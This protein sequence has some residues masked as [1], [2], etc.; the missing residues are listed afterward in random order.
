M[1]SP[2]TPASAASAGSR[3]RTATCEP[4]EAAPAPR[5][6]STKRPRR[7]ERRQR[8]KGPSGVAPAWRRANQEVHRE[9]NFLLGEAWCNQFA[10]LLRH[11]QTHGTFAVD[12]SRDPRLAGWCAKQRSRRAQ[13]TL[14]VPARA[15]LEG[16]GFLA[17]GGGSGGER[18]PAPAAPAA[19]PRTG[20]AVLRAA[21]AVSARGEDRPP[22]CGSAL[23]AERDARAEYAAHRSA[24][25]GRGVSFPPRFL[26][27][28]VAPRAP[29]AASSPPS[30]PPTPGSTYAEYAA[31]S[32]AASAASSTAASLASSDDGSGFSLSAS[33][34]AL[35]PSRDAP[36]DAPSD[37][38]SRPSTRAVASRP[39]T[40]A[41]T[42]PRPKSVRFDLR[43][44][45]TAAVEANLRARVA[46]CDWCGSADRVRTVAAGARLCAACGRAAT[47]AVRRAEATST[48][49]EAA[50][51]AM[52]VPSDS[53]AG[54]APTCAFAQRPLRSASLPVLRAAAGPPRRPD[55][56]R[57]QTPVKIRR[58]RSRRRRRRAEAEEKREEERAEA[59]Q[60]AEES[61]RR[62]RSRARTPPPVAS[63][64]ARWARD[65][66]WLTLL[67]I[68]THLSGPRADL[69]RWLT[70][71]RGKN[72]KKHADYGGGLVH[73]DGLS[74]ATE[75][76]DNEEKRKRL[77][78]VA[79]RA[80]DAVWG[81]SDDAA[82]PTTAD[83]DDKARWV[84]TDRHGWGRVERDAKHRS[85]TPPNLF[86]RQD[87]GLGAVAPSG[88]AP[89]PVYE[90]G[91]DRR[92]GRPAAEARRLF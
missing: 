16:C 6:K 48:A 13:G 8:A 31:S 81:L 53:I 21:A 10:E 14:S 56:I 90:L 72:L 69:T 85:W 2:T 91:L 37:A 86:E 54:H 64:M 63:V 41:T 12:A 75:F 3:V 67:A 76:F 32:N 52:A 46:A 43:T 77:N 1:S 30:L 71:D 58:V 38:D 34:A 29:P 28:A 20:A 18:A 61:A 15:R 17:V 62:P 51:A 57:L 47:P 44:N 40:N 82:K 49:A 84:R 39:S 23:R 50:A 73:L 36:S 59:A 89:M 87:G 7:R 88:G 66:G 9:H 22:T 27:D 11:R 92:R 42:A 4:I 45:V 25:G 33:A 74:R 70:A 19:P 68:R 35:P 60:A 78:A 26:E 55:P 79:A 24:G 80:L 65:G 83:D 5:Q